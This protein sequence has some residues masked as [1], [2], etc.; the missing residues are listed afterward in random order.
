MNG[1]ANAK[2]DYQSIA[3]CRVCSYRLRG[4]PEERCP[5]CGTYFD[6]K[7]PTTMDLGLALRPRISRDWLLP[8]GRWARR[9]LWLVTLLAIA[10]GA[11]PLPWA[12]VLLGSMFPWLILGVALR[13]RT[14]M[15]RRA[16]RFYQQPKSAARVDDRLRGR[17]RLQFLIVSLAVAFHVP[18]YVLFFAHSRGFNHLAHDIMDNASTP[19]TPRRIGLFYVTPSAACPHGLTAEVWLGSMVYNP[20]RIDCDTLPQRGWPLGGD[21]YIAGG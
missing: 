18:L 7:D 1:T 13:V 11:I 2:F 4:L 5:E 16:V 17:V 9:C 10:L 8:T 3:L 14:G 12:V 21:W 20:T 15:R 6:A 19:L